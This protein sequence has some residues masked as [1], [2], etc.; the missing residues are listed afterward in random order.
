[1][2]IAIDASRAAL[3][4]RTGTERYSLEL[5]RALL[6]IDRSNEYRLYFNGA[7][8][9]GLFSSGPNWQAREIALRRLWTH[10]R[11]SQALRHDRPD[12]LFVPAHVLP[13]F[14]ARRNV[15]TV[16]DLGFRFFPGTHRRLS[17]WYLELS[18]RWAAHRATRLIA[19][20]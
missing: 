4:E 1:M 7:P 9:A 12:V 11:L 6:R 5:I 20:S 19:I 8:P 16:H 10:L 3:A 15:V 18:T 2:R 17:R 14:P 13:M